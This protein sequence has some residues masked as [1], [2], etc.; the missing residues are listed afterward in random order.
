MPYVIQIHGLV[1][2]QPSRFDEEFFVSIDFDRCAPGECNLITSLDPAKARHFDDVLAA[3]EAWMT[4]DPRYPV[5][6]DGRP[7]RPLTAFSVL[8]ERAP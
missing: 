7:N 8:I 4:V 1:N 6:D 5:R 2:G 3:R